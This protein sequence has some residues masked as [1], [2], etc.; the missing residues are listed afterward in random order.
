MQNTYLDVI[1]W[2]T[3]RENHQDDSSRRDFC[4]SFQNQNVG[5]CSIRLCSNVY[6]MCDD[7][8][9]FP[10]AWFY[11]DEQICEDF[12]RQALLKPFLEITNFDF[13]NFQGKGFGR[14]GLKMMYNLSQKLGAE[15]KETL[16]KD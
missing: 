6:A 4:F 13:S 1:M 16:V 14:M 11:K 15:A 9:F 8:R 2:K 5:K 3:D 7:R 12:G 10:D